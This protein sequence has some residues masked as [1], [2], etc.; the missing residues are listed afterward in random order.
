MSVKSCSLNQKL[1]LNVSNTTTEG[2]SLRY[3]GSISVNWGDGTEYLYSNSDTIRSFSHTYS[4]TYSGDI[5]LRGNI[6]TIKGFKNY[7]GSSFSS[8]TFSQVEF[9][10]LSNLE[11]IEQEGPITTGRFFNFD[12]SNLPYSLINTYITGQNKC[13]GEIS[14]LP[15]NLTT[16]SI[17]GNNT[18]SGNIQTFFGTWS[19]PSIS[20]TLPNLVEI[21]IGG[22]NSLTGN[23]SSLSRGTVSASSSITKLSISG[24]NTIAGTL[25]YINYLPSLEEIS[26]A[27]SNTI[28]GTLS[29]STI[30]EQF[31]IQGNN[32][33]SGDIISLS[34]S[35]SLQLFRLWGAT[36][37]STTGDIQYLPTSL[38]R[39][40][41]RGGNTTY[42]DIQYLP[43]SLTYYENRGSNT[44]S[45]NIISLSGTSMSYYYNSGSNSVTGD[46]QYLPNTMR[47]F[48]SYGNSTI[49]GD[50]ISLSASSIQV[51]QTGVN[52]TIVG[53]IKHLPSNLA[54]FVV[55]NGMITGSVSNLPASLQSFTIQTGSHSLSGDINFLPAN[56]NLFS[57]R[58]N[59]QKLDYTGGRT[60]APQM[61]NVYIQAPSTIFG[62]TSSEV[63]N[64][65][66][67]LNNTTWNPTGPRI[68][69]I[70]NGPR[71][72]TSD[73]AVF[74]LTS[75]GVVISI[76]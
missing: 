4:A 50:I 63:D 3:K 61:I 32:T 58:N 20:P 10:K 38:I 68:E 40:E 74:G 56:T 66:I 27:G 53:D 65:L 37:Q 55:N 23:L 1:T 9:V 16:F 30:L 59:Y 49:S 5:I 15:Q 48:Y 73:S 6:N 36:S 22:S 76:S 13:Y 8:V 45:G 71:T 18:I 25:S 12:V 67:D 24:N 21:S 34:S 70:N 26:I 33:I 42:G 7:K 69:L 72:S 60:W 75:K 17:L 28:S 39:Y 14:N 19:N 41:N 44:T 47:Q 29:T 35:T 46:I 54:N 62:L 11:D 51:F 43:S 64:L 57:I 2:F 52:S 31:S